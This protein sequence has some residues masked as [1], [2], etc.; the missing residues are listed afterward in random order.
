MKPIGMWTVVG[1]AFRVL[2]ANFHI[3]LFLA[4]VTGGL[5]AVLADLASD[6]MVDVLHPAKGQ[7]IL[8]VT[9]LSALP[10][11]AI[12]GSTVGAWAAAAGIYLW[13]QRERKQ[14]A[15]L[16]DAINFGLNRF[17]RVFPA[18]AKAFIAVL[19][20]MIVAV[21]GILFGLQYAYV[22]AIATLDKDEPNPLTRSR[23]L[24]ASRRRTIFFT[25]CLFLPWWIPFDVGASLYL[26]DQ[27]RLWWFVGGTIDHL[28]L[29]TID[30]IMVQY[31]LDMFRK[32]AT[33]Q[34]PVT[35]AR[36]TSP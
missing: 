28:V 36:A 18:H 31:Y 4:V 15:N 20:G 24:T 2:F 13:V 7:P 32:P 19:L 35:E 10:I 33:E 16:Y 34:P 14:S 5:G 12:W 26:L 9:Q 11:Q 27:S 3:A 30:L 22:D 29:L 25:F 23:K 1:N 8:A 17:P 21:P 6:I